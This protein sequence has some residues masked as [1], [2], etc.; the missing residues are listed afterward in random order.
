M[1][2]K[3]LYP[4]TYF[5]KIKLIYLFFLILIATFFE[6]VSLGT[7]MPVISAMVEE[8]TKDILFFNYINNFFTISSRQDFIKTILLII[9]FVFIIKFILMSYITLT[10][11]FFTNKLNRHVSERLLKIYLNQ[12]IVWHS[13]F[14]KSSFLNLLITEV[15][16]YTGH[17]IN[18]LFH[19][20]IDLSIFFGIITFLFF[21][22]TKI[23]LYILIFSSCIFFLIFFFSKK[24][25][26]KLGK[27]SEKTSR[28]ILT[29][30]NENLSGIKEIILYSGSNFILNKFENLNNLSLKNAALHESYQDILRF[31]LEF[32]GLIVILIIFYVMFYESEINNKSLQI[33]TLG[34]Y[35]AS[36]FKLMPIFNR[37]STYSQKLRF[38]VASVEKVNDFLKTQT[39]NEKILKKI[40][41]QIQNEIFLK[42]ITYSYNLNQNIIENINLKI[43]KNTLVGIK[44]ESGSG[45]TTLSNVIMNLIRPNE[46][47]IFVDGKDI[48]KNNL[49]Y[50]NSIGFV[51]QNFFHIDDTL[52]KNI[53]LNEDKINYSL[54]RNSLKNSLLFKTIRNKQLRL[55]D[56]LGNQALKISG[57]QLQRINI[58]RA[59]YRNPK[60]L[61]L[62]EPTSALDSGSRKELTEI[63]KKLKKNMTI[64]LITHSNEMLN[65]CDEMYEIKNKKLNQL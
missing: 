30:L 45:K 65:I 6:I 32:F 50:Q 42:N 20:I 33:G 57:G 61:I 17:T 58:A 3:I 9:F 31:V 46:G 38:G 14:N 27:V 54:L 16:K 7:L 44:G 29:F 15:K 11:N 40:D 37:V 18:P 12:S 26:Y 53:T 56:K 22:N 19:I 59:L 24:I 23:F 25:S 36:L 4:L 41:I 1:I 13:N 5:S 55:K 39:N 48:Y 51:S 28:T 62:D 52:L 47:T 63:I 10:C 64:V 43:K 8:N 2:K 49:S 34:M 60:I 35:A 21:L